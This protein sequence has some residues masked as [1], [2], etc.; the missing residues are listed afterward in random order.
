MGTKGKRVHLKIYQLYLIKR[1]E[2]AQ[3][4]KVMLSKNKKTMCNSKNKWK[5]TKL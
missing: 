1:E 2:G 3:A 4:L 5:G